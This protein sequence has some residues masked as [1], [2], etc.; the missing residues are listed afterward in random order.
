M[1]FHLRI[2]IVAALA[3]GSLLGSG[4]ARAEIAF[5]QEITAPEG[6]IVIYQPQPERLT[7]IVLNG[8]AAM[9]LILEGKKE[10]IF[11]AFW[12]TAKIDRDDEAGT[13]TLRELEVTRVRWPDSKESDEARFTEIVEAAAAKATLTVATERLSASLASAE[14]EQ[15][16][17]AE[18]KNDPPKMVFSEKL[19]ILLLYDGEPIW[20]DVEDSPYE[21]ALNTAF[22]VVRDKRTKSCFLTSGKLWYSAAEPGGPWTPLA[23]PPDDLVKMLPKPD[24]DS[25]APSP[26]PAV[27]VATEPTE[28]VVSDGP[29]EWKPVGEGELLYVQNTETPWLREVSTGQTW[30]LLSGRWFRAATTAGP[31]SFVR[32]DQLPDSFRKIPE[33]SDIGGVRVSIAGTEEAEDALLDAAIPQTTAIRRSEAKLEVKYDGAP[34][35]EKIP[36]TTVSRAVNTPVQVLEIGGRFYAVDD[37]VWFVAAKAE[38]PW[39]VADEVPEDEIAKIPPSSSAYNV[40]H[41]HV[42]Q[43]TPEIVYV[44]YTPGYLWSFPYYGV[45]VYGTGWYYPYYPGY[46]Y[47]RPVTYGFHVGYNPWTGWNFGMSWNVGFMHFGVGWSGGYHGVWGG[48]WGHGCGGWYGG[49]RPVWG[50]YYGGGHTHI[51][52]NSSINYGNRVQVSNRIANNPRASNLRQPS[53]YNR[54]EARTRNA[55]RAAIRGS[56]QQARSAGKLPNNVFADPNGNVGRHTDKGWQSRDGQKWKSA[57]PSRARTSGSTGS[58]TRSR[59]QTFD[60]R[61]VQRDYQARQRG[62]QRMT[63]QHSAPRGGGGRFR[64]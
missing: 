40:T 44:G 60:H 24:D 2:L 63:M 59:P 12:F 34:K 14:R 23:T 5:P 1:R 52:I 62:S 18:L 35:F 31:W 36:G 28:L 30:V 48:Y 45:P 55:D 47:P 10:P 15:K 7:G 3:A 43:S 46:Y 27:V 26:P 11:G 39:A 20:G 21:R 9:S 8:R 33:A 29:P 61:S 54:P 50:G 53:V 6:K 17:L 49:Y 64:H 57:E 41:V 22:V 51:N 58:S 32:G 25:P 37:G 19:A 4:P 13:T 42:Y 16:S 38:G 56:A